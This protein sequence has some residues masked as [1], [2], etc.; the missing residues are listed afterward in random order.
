[1][2]LKRVI[3]RGHAPLAN[4]LDGSRHIHDQLGIAVG[5]ES[6]LKRP[7]QLTASISEIGA[8]SWEFSNWR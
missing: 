2:R 7:A 6:T 4:Q 1:M 5:M 8:Q 3:E